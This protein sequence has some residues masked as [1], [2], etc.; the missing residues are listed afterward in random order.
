MCAGMTRLTCFLLLFAACRTEPLSGSAETSTP[1]AACAALTTV[2][3][4]D[5]RSD[6]I[7]IFSGSEL[8]NSNG[9][10]NHFGQCVERAE[11]LCYDVAHV[12][13]MDCP[14]FDRTCADG[15]VR[16]WQS[17]CEIGCQRAAECN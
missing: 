9:C 15:F 4:C 13:P 16:A 14:A 2:D 7:S 6:C 5:A 1:P 10:E 3:A 8:C 11:I 17:C 12:C